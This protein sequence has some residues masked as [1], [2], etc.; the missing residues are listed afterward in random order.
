MAQA[1]VRAAPDSELYLV[2]SSVVDAPVFVGVRDSIVKYATRD[3]RLTAAEAEAAVAR[4]DADGSSDRVIRFGWWDDDHLPVM[5]GSP[6]DGWYHIRRDRLV[7]Y[8]QALLHDDEQ[9]AV[10]LLECW[11]RHDEAETGC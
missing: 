1:I 5:E 10:A 9:A 11:E 2:W 8:A 4:A 7:E 6:S 3:W